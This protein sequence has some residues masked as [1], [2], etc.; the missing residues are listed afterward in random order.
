MEMLSKQQGELEMDLKS[1]TLTNMFKVRL[2]IDSKITCTKDSM[3]QQQKR[4]IEMLSKQQRE[5]EVD[6]KSSTLTTIFKV[7][8]L[9]ECKIC[10]P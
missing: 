2:L 8:L 6:L 7:R 10:V 5:L 9:I 3:K 4:I 1:S